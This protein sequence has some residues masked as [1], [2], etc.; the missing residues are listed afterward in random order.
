MCVELFSFN[1]WTKPPE[2]GGGSSFS[3]L[4]MNISPGFPFLNGSRRW[5]ENQLKT[6]IIHMLRG[7]QI[8]A[9]LLSLNLSFLRSLSRL[10]CASLILNGK[11]KKK[12][13]RGRSKRYIFWQDFSSHAKNTGMKLEIYKKP[14]GSRSRA[15]LRDECAGREM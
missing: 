9:N 7:K 5:A 13:V 10:V 15:E 6:C 12:K 14:S 1:N 8:T 3:D 11:K 4:N 2:R